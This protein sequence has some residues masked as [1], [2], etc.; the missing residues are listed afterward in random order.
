MASLETKSWLFWTVIALSSLG[1]IGFLLTFTTDVSGVINQSIIINFLNGSK[2]GDGIYLYNDSDT[3]YFNETKLNDTIDNKIE[4]LTLAQEGNLILF[5]LNKDAGSFCT[6]CAGNKTLSTSP[7]ATE[8]TLSGSNLPDGSTLIGEWVTIPGVPNTEFIPPGN[9]HV[10]V[11]GEKTVGTKIVQFYYEIYK[12]NKTGGN[13]V[14]LS[15]SGYSDY[16]PTSR[17]SLDIYTY[18]EGTNLNLTDRLKVKGYAYVSGGGSAPDVD[19]YIQGASNT[20]IE[21][22]IGSVSVENFVPYTGAIKNVDLG[23]YNLTL[24]GIFV[25]N[26]SNSREVCKSGCEFDTIQG[27][28]DS[29]NDAAGNKFYE[30]R[31]HSGIYSECITGKNF[32]YLTGYGSIMGLPIVRCDSG[33]V[34]Q[35]PTAISGIEKIALYS[36]GI[37]DDVTLVN[38][39][40]GTHGFSGTRFYID[41]DSGD[42]HY[43]LADIKNNGAFIMTDSQLQINDYKSTVGNGET[44]IFNLSDSATLDIASTQVEIYNADIDDDLTFIKQEN[45]AYYSARFTSNNFEISMVNESYSGE[46][47][48]YKAI[49]NNTEERLK[50]NLVSLESLG[51]G[52]GYIYYINA[53]EDNLTLA[54]SHNS[55]TVKG[56]DDNYYALVGENNTLNAKYDEVTASNKTTGEGTFNFIYSTV[57]GVLVMS[58]SIGIGTDEP[59]NKI[60]IKAEGSNPAY[61]QMTNDISGHGAIN[62]FYFGISPNGNGGLYSGLTSTIEVLPFL[63]INGKYVF[64]RDGWFNIT[65]A[66]HGIYSSEGI[67]DDDVS[68]YG[69][70]NATGTI[71]SKDINLNN[72]MSGS[73]RISLSTEPINTNRKIDISE[74]LKDNGEVGYGFF[75]TITLDT[76][77]EEF[78][79]GSLTGIFGYPI[80]RSN[81]FSAGTSIVGLDFAGTFSGG[82]SGSKNIRSTAI[83]VIGFQS[84][85]GS[86]IVNT[87]TGLNVRPSANVFSSG[88]N[89]TAL[90]GINILDSMALIE[91]KNQ[92]LLTLEK[93]TAAD[94]N[95]QLVLEGNDDGT[96]IWFDED[97]RIYSD[98]TNF[99]I[100]STSG[101]VIIYNNTGYGNI[102]YGNAIEH[103]YKTDKTDEE[104]Y[105]LVQYALSHR[106]NEE[107]YSAWGECYT[108]DYVKNYSIPILVNITEEVCEYQPK[109]N[110]TNEDVMELHNKGIINPYNYGDYIEE[111]CSMQEVERTTYPYFI[112]VPGTNV[113]CKNVMLQKSHKYLTQAGSPLNL[114]N[115]SIALTGDTALYEHYV[116]NTTKDKQTIDKIQTTRDYIADLSFS[117]LSTL[118][119][120]S[121]TGKLTE[122]V[123]DFFNLKGLIGS[124]NLEK[125]AHYSFAMNIF[126]MWENL[127]QEQEITELN[128]RLDTIESDLCNQG[129]IKYC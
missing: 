117:E 60:T 7:N 89:A 45:K 119:I 23:S 24:N 64:Q 110:L 18:F 11:V 97:K 92:T 87:A 8:V 109:G 113:G 121:D 90:F 21:I 122:T 54:S 91:G 70:L 36:M 127:Q 4:N 19:A 37:T 120:D 59:T 53:T 57:E 83:N 33:T 30:V 20:R 55:L 115:N 50:Y 63:G 38:I 99:I 39:T 77:E 84:F 88:T 3:M 44:I 98:G 103:T 31:V 69:D 112:E 61:M 118:I 79:G 13:S 76:L 116:T 17:T 93:P 111:V 102:H 41:T 16:V 22:P 71:Y 35:A 48:F 43:R 124:Y 12:I 81:N 95:F 34:Y 78:T 82:G 52:K 15:T 101:D 66:T 56:F 74:I 28:I 129:Y 114:G 5:F 106:G 29:I 62:G 6:F 100:N 96:G 1:F 26:I 68:V 42:I 9:W 126:L 128:S 47:I 125:I 72:T 27:A 40:S 107:N 32:V 105:N 2:K 73:G 51:G 75:N 58:D 10:H 123:I 104:A 14:L 108:L 49:N 80:I 46:T 67:F 94:N 86:G 25:R 65:E 85:F